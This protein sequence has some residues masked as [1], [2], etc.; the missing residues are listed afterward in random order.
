MLHLLAP[1]LLL[2][3]MTALSLVTLINSWQGPALRKGLA[4]AGFLIFAFLLGLSLWQAYSKRK[5]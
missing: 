5:P 1:R 3:A 4:L 2:L